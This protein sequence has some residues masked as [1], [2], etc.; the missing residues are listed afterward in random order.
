M[1]PNEAKV[2]QTHH[3]W[4]DRRSSIYGEEILIYL[5]ILLLIYSENAFQPI[6]RCH[7]QDSLVYY[8]IY[9]KTK[10]GRIRNP[11]VVV[12]IVRITAFLVEKKV[13]HPN[14]KYP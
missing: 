8:I 4:I 14:I 7:M 12:W 2:R 10:S 3:Q 13:T 9:P 1:R 6:T 5:H 11:L